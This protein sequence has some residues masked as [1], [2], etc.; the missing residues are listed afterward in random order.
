[1]QLMP[2]RI[3]IAA[4]HTVQAV[5]DRALTTT[6]RALLSKGKLQELERKRVDRL[7]KELYDELYGRGRDG[8]G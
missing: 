8:Q 4:T 3:M 1:M 2:I 7:I 5:M 6:E